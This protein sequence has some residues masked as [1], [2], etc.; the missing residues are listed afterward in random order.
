M[1]NSR[2]NYINAEIDSACTQMWKRIKTLVFNR[3]ENL[4]KFVI[5]DQVEYSDN[6]DIVNKFNTF[7]Y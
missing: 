5:F 6:C 3:K 1:E 4:T 7:F 2:N